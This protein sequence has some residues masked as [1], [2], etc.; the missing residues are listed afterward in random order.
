MMI[1]ADAVSLLNELV[2]QRG[3][4][5]T[6][7]R[8]AAVF[9]WLVG[10]PKPSHSLLRLPSLTS[11]TEGQPSKSLFLRL[12]S[13]RCRGLGARGPAQITTL[14]SLLCLNALPVGRKCH[15]QRPCFCSLERSVAAVLEPVGLSKPSL[16]LHSLLRL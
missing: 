8:S 12:G 15:P 3:P 10:L 5:Y 9:S 14:H 6:L 4:F 13:E 1:C 2:E 16:G 11:G 7:D